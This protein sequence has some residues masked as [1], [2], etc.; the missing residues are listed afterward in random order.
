MKT[1]T[2]WLRKALLLLLICG[3]PLFGTGCIFA[4]LGGGFGG[5]GVGR[6]L[7]SG[8][9]AAESWAAGASAAAASVVAA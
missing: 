4:G 7:G 6:L 1:D 9:T 2:G 8:S 3:T 5:G